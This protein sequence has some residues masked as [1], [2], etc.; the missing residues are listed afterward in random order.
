MSKPTQRAFLLVG[1]FVLSEVAA[2]A[3]YK[4][5]YAT[6]LWDPS[7]APNGEFELTL[8]A[9]GLFLLWPIGMVLYAKLHMNRL[10]PPGD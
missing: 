3:L 9:V 5:W 6:L 4:L 8:K 2:W 7:T 1:T 10:V